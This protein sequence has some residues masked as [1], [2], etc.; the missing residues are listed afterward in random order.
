MADPIIALP[1]AFGWF[2]TEMRAPGNRLPADR[3]ERAKL[4]S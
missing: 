2:I 4:T 1:V 3:Y